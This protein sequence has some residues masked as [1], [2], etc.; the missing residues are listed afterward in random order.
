VLILLVGGALL[1]AT[2]VTLLLLAAMDLGVSLWY[3]LALLIV[4][5]AVLATGIA[6]LRDRE[7]DWP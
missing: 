7:H 5:A 6:G 1:A 3:G 2:A 4:A